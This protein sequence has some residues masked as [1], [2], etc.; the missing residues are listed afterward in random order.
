MVRI[1]AP[2]D[3]KRGIQPPKSSLA[4]ALISHR[5]QFRIIKINNK[6]GISL[7]KKVVVLYALIT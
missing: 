1:P 4:K 6:I 3:I 7:I 2:L 5:R